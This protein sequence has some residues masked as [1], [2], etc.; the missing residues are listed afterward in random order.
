[1]LV[2]IAS[3]ALS[4]A[5]LG[6]ARSPAPEPDHPP[7][8]DSAATTVTVMN[9]EPQPVTI[10]LEH[11]DLDL[12]LGVVEAR[13]T[14]TFEVPRWLVLDRKEI[15]FFAVPK[16]RLEQSTAPTVLRLGEHLG[17]RVPER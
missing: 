8:P 10:Y 5:L 2:S 14:T 12:R 6:T 11:D 15:E 17:I 3:I 4:G 7:A 1:M 13:D 9:Q 16:S